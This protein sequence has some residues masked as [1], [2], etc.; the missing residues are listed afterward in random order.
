MASF[1]IYNYQFAKVMKRAEEGKLFHEDG[2]MEA[3]DAFPI[4]QEILDE[5]INK[6]FLKEKPV[7]FKSKRSDKEYIH[8]YLIPPTDNI[9]IIKVAN[10]RMTTIV[11]QDL[12]DIQT[13]D[14]QN[15]LVIIDNRKGIQ[16]ILIEQKKAAFQDVKQ[17][18]DIITHT[19]NKVLEKYHLVIELMHLQ[20]PRVF[21]EFVNDKR[22]YPT[23]FYKISF[24]LPH[25]NLERL[26]KVYDKMLIKSREVFGGDLAW[27]HKANKNGMLPLDEKNEFQKA[28]ID[29][30]MSEVGSENIKLYPN[31]SKRKAIV[32]GENSFLTLTISD[33][34]IKKL[35]EDAASGDLFGSKALD[36]VKIKTKTGI[37]IKGTE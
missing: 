10:R 15:C 16:R 26:K 9:F 2:E 30:M 33:T 22:S 35:P 11:T 4:R 23:G 8:K 24:H 28:L 20:E 6:D 5:V 36:E 3:D 17:V 12:K 18:A 7:V 14:Y 21:W 19:F 34:V 13:D 32:V 27:S 37:D 1:A 29:W 25:L 31:I